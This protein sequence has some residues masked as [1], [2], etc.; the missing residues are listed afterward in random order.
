MSLMTYYDAARKSDFRL[1]SLIYDDVVTI[2]ATD[3]LFGC[4]GISVQFDF[5]SE[6][7]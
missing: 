1:Q 2:G 5:V 6:R 3:I 4:N 7:K